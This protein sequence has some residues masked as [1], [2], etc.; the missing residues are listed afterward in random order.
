MW[1]FQPCLTTLFATQ[2]LLATNGL[3][4]NQTSKYLIHSQS[5][6]ICDIP[7]NCLQS[8]II[9]MSCNVSNR[10]E[11]YSLQRKMLNS[12]QASIDPS[13]PEFCH[14]FLFTAS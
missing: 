3:L 12:R 4:E 10:N 8:I 5:P 2:N 7:T 13:D 6:S 9:E 14:S 11:K 1:H